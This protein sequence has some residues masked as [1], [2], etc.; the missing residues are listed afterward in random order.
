M[1]AR[2]ATG[3][4]Q[5]LFLVLRVPTTTPFPG[6][7]QMAPSILLDG[8]PGGTNDVPINNRSFVSVDGVN[9][10]LDAFFNY[11]FSLRLG[12]PQGCDD[13]RDGSD[14]CGLHP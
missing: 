6:V 13:D 5:N 7:S 10:T 1:R 2:I 11:R 12:E 3:E 14:L 4:I 8:V 9:F